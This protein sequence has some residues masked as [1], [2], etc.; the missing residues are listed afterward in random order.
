MKLSAGFWILALIAVALAIGIYY[1]YVPKPTSVAVDTV[2][3]TP[4]PSAP[5]TDKKELLRRAIA[6]D[7]DAQ[8]RLSGRFSSGDRGLPFNPILA[9]YWASLSAGAHD[10]CGINNLATLYEDGTG[11]GQDSQTSL[12]LYILAASLG[13]LNAMANLGRIY[14]YGGDGVQRDVLTAIDWYKKGADLGDF[15]SMRQLGEI[16]GWGEG[17]PLN[18]NRSSAYL[19]RANP[20]HDGEASYDLGWLYF[21]YY[22]RADRCEQALRWLT[23]S[24]DLGDSDGESM[25]GWM[26]D[27]GSCM[28]AREPQTAAKWYRLAM[29]YDTAAET[30]YAMLLWT[31]ELGRSDERQAIQLYRDAALRGDA[32]AMYLLGNA[33]DHGTA[34]LPDKNVAWSYFIA[35]ADRGQV[36]AISVVASA[37][38]RGFRVKQDKVRALGMFLAAESLGATF[39]ASDKAKLEH[40]LTPAQLADAQ[41]FAFAFA[42]HAQA[43]SDVLYP[44][45]S[46]PINHDRRID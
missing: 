24:A 40:Q 26:Y 46:P 20:I 35:A 43:E 1:Y 13:D 10:P 14:Y 25:L 42:S 3:H 44:W 30:N 39:K 22:P 5:P 11:V 21:R 28:K 19:L 33:Y 18:I 29:A 31:G 6:G 16:Y 37:Y 8:C 23:T 2:V 27:S 34:V 38:Y 36:A 4:K 41:K 7:S 45:L 32:T 17:V 12:K 9:F 15:T